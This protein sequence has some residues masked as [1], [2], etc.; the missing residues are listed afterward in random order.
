MDIFW[1]YT[2][3]VS[4]KTGSITDIELTRTLWISKECTKVACTKDH[5]LLSL[6]PI[7]VIMLH[8][9]CRYLDLERDITGQKCFIN[10]PFKFSTKS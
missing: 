1:N 3:L 5:R 4:D 6:F 9:R 7:L 2:L 10:I 8:H